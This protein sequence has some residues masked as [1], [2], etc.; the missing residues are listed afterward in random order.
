M[1]ALISMTFKFILIDCRCVL[2]VSS[3]G[4]NKQD[5]QDIREQ[6][7]H[8]QDNHEDTS[9]TLNGHTQASPKVLLQVGLLEVGLLG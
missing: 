5:R 8:G 4:G 6:D 1:P 9:K 3:S 2:F 7:V